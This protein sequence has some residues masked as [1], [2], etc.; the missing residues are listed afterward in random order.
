MERASSID[1]D[2]VYVRDSGLI[3][4]CAQSVRVRKGRIQ[5]RI[6]MVPCAGTPRCQCCGIR[7]AATADGDVHDDDH[8][9]GD[10]DNATTTCTKM[11]EGIGTLTL[12]KFTIGR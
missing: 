8:D 12:H 6:E 3:V 2:G 1:D 11:K 7:H 5:M 4:D 10:G 9:N